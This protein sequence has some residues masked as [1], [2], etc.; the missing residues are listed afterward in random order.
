[1]AWN[2]YYREN[3]VV[4]LSYSQ[5]HSIKKIEK[6]LYKFVVYIF[7]FLL[8]PFASKLVNYSRHNEP[9]KFVWKSTNRF[10]QRKMSLISEFFWMFDYSL[11]LEKMTNLDPK[12]A[13]RSVKM[14]AINF[15]ERVFK[16]G[17][18]HTNCGLS[19]IRSVHN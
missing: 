9:M 12:S 4:Y 8:T 2:C 6:I 18:L 15:Y 3:F 17:L 11:W 19:N 14:R 5:S 7:T 1:M 13:K 10:Y 16:N